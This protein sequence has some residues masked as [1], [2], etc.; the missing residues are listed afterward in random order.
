MQS[1]GG[2]SRHTNLARV[3]VWFSRGHVL[4]VQ[5]YRFELRPDGAQVRPMRR[6]CGSRQFVFDK[7]LA[8]Q[9]AR[10]ADGEKRLS[11]ADLCEHLTA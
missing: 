4:R 11:Y 1:A 9:K 2:G 10:Y 5:A 6:S 3:P 7:A 8:L